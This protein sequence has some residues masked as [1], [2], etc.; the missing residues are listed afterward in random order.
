MCLDSSWTF[1]IEVR[2]F[3]LAEGKGRDEWLIQDRIIITVRHSAATI[4]L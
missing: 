3:L 1:I 2:L 4:P